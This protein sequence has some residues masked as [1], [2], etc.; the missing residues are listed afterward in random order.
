M[1]APGKTPFFLSKAFLPLLVYPMDYFFK[2]IKPHRIPLE[3]N[4]VFW[5]Q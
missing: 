5:T 1:R 4:G 2:H 3:R